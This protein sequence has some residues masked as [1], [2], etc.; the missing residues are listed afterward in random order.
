MSS[1]ALDAFPCRAWWRVGGERR[2][3]QGRHGTTMRWKKAYQGRQHKGNVEGLDLDALA[4]VVKHVTL[5]ERGRTRAT[6]M[7]GGRARGGAARRRWSRRPFGAAVRRTMGSEKSSTTKVPSESIQS[8]LSLM[9]RCCCAGERCRNSSGIWGRGRG[10]CAVARTH[11]AR[12]APNPLAP[13][14]IFLFVLVVLVR[15]GAILGNV[16]GVW[17]RKEQEEAA[18]GVRWRRGWGGRIC[19]SWCPT[20]RATGRTILDVS[21]VGRGKGLGRHLMQVLALREK[22]GNE[23][24]VRPMRATRRGGQRHATTGPTRADQ[25]KSRG[26]TRTLFLRSSLPSWHSPPN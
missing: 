24:R 3:K 10:G 5:E 8:A 12:E 17:V 6:G 7:S 22:R 16:L 26:Q 15:G 14:H 21:V 1:E 23:R 9:A 20:G 25:N 19:C 11:V 2:R 18:R 13:A 4:N